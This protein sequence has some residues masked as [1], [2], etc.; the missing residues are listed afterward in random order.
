[1]I[2]FCWILLGI[3]YC[4]NKHKPLLF[5]KHMGKFYTFLHK[6]HEISILYIMLA[7]I[8]EWLYFD[9]NY[10]ERWLSL[11]FC[12]LVN[13]YFLIY[14]LYVYYDMIKYPVA[15][16]GNEKYEY[17]AIRYGS[18]LKNVRFDEYDVTYLL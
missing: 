5:K 7:T 12:I 14:E 10:M 11:G 18:M 3:G 15:V 16:V 9:S 8:M 13:V 6:V 2:L 1:M 17:Y 4:L